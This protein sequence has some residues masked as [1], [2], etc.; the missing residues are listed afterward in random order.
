MKRL[1]LLLTVMILIGAL[2]LAMTSCF[3][4]TDNGTGGTNDSGNGDGGTNG[5]QDGG[6]DAEYTPAGADSVYKNVFVAALADKY[7]RL[8]SVKE[9]KIAVIGGSSVAFGLDSDTLAL[10]TGKEVVNFGL[11]ATLG[12]KIMLDI[13]EDGLNPGD[14]VVFAPEL[15]AKTLSLYFGARA[16]WQAIDASNQA[17]YNSVYKNNA[18]ALD[19]E[20]DAFLTELRE[21]L[22]IG[23][24]DPSGVY[25]RKSFDVYGD[26][27]Y[28]R[29]NNTMPLEYDPNTLFTLSTDIVSDE[30]LEY[31]NAYCD[32]MRARGIA[33]YFS[34]CPINSLALSEGV[35]DETISE[36]EIYLAKN[37]HCPIISSLSEHIMHPGYFF[38]T[39]L[40][41]N[42]AGVV[43]RTE[44]LIND[45]RAAMELGD[46]IKL[47]V[48]PPPGTGENE[49]VEGNNVHADLFAY[50][51]LK[52]G[53][54]VIGLSIVGLS[55]KA[56]DFTDE[57]LII[58]SSYE[59]V[60][61]IMLRANVLSGFNSLKKITIG[62][63]MSSIEDYA[64]AG[65]ETVTE[66]HAEF[67]T[68]CLVSIP[69]EN[70]Q[71]GFMEG[72]GEGCKL[73]VK[74]EYLNDFFNHYTWQHYH[75]YLVR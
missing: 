29:P 55:E 17:L 38:D 47:H 9:P 21:Y 41:L 1:F 44:M 27:S 46:E 51:E 58:P 66:I 50:E 7:D 40:H 11:F 23:V 68:E 10:Y 74:P 24:P 70:A 62:P 43:A 4:P 6:D 63:N 59:G 5:S 18:E 30:F 56:K 37:L 31:F 75:K 2:A 48:P 60:P 71:N 64:F 69:G 45:L 32:R 19:S 61:V 15:D 49:T 67:T 73:Y 14:T 34:Y 54:K 72:V 20:K 33:V 35:T 16:A 36:L 42:E 26:I 52:V 39:N 25:N 53:D 8:V 22:E 28:P 12:S 13:S 3:G 57:E 65:C